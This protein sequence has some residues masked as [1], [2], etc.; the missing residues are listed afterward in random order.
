VCV[1]SRLQT[2]SCN[3]RVNIEVVVGGMLVGGVGVCFVADGIAALGN[4]KFIG[5]AATGRV[6]ELL[7]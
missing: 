6:Q 4:N 2:S 7:L 3:R 1:G 5:C